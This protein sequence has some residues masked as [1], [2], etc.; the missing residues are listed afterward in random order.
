MRFLAVIVTS[1]MFVLTGL[2][3]ALAADAAD[4]AIIGFSGDGRFFAFEEFGIQDGSGFPY[5][6]IYVIDLEKDRWVEG[7]PEH[8]E[9]RLRSSTTPQALALSGLRTWVPPFCCHV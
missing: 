6:N 3:T 2:T 5:A 4:R 8:I 7:S 9:V 1:L